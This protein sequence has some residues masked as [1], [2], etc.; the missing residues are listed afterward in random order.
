MLNAFTDAEKTK[1]AGI[2]DS[3]Q[4]NPNTILVTRVNTN[5]TLDG[6]EQV[7]PFEPAYT[8]VSVGLTVNA[9]GTITSGI[10]GYVNG[11]LS[12][13]INKINGLLNDVIVWLEKKPISTGAWEL[14]G[15]GMSEISYFN[16]GGHVVSLASSIPVLNGD[17]IRIMIKRVSGNGRLEGVDR[18]VSLG[19]IRQYPATLVAFQ[20]ASF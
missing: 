19:N 3:S 20:A 14:V 13:Y 6:T 1:L 7:I 5:L 18:T 15:D 17:E 4:A 9:G 12:M 11:E 8:S 16:D 2:E 10:N